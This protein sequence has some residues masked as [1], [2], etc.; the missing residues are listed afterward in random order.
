M[1]SRWLGL[2][3]IVGA[4]WN[5][6]LDVAQFWRD[7]SVALQSYPGYLVCGERSELEMAK[8]EDPQGITSD[9]VFGL[10]LS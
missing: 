2:W 4:V 9:V 8:T 10:I 7:V 5:M 1:G 6:V 3:N